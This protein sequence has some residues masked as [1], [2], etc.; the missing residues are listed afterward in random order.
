MKKRLVQ[1]ETNDNRVGGN[2]W[3]AALG[4]ASLSPASAGLQ[5]GHELLG[6]LVLQVGAHVA[7]VGAVCVP[8]EQAAVGTHRWEL[9]SHSL[10]LLGTTWKRR[11][12]SPVSLG[13]L[14]PLDKVLRPPR[15]QVFTV[16]VGEG[17]LWV[18]LHVWELAGFSQHRVFI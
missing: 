3:G 11:Q 9:R 5:P 6:R 14:Q 15:L 16:V 1:T 13:V 7:G 2:I 18:S 17:P 10:E 12:G 4:S 8:S